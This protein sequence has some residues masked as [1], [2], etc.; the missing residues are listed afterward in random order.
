MIQKRNGDSIANK[1]EYS[2]IPANGVTV[3]ARVVNGALTPGALQTRPRH[4][5]V[6]ALAVVIEPLVVDEV[7]LRVWRNSGEVGKMWRERQESKLL[8]NHLPGLYPMDEYRYM[9]SE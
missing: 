4:T 5:T 6:L 2:N 1:S 9:G 3:H 7:A 8:G